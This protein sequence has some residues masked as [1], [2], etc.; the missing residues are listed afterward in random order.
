MQELYVEHFFKI[1]LFWWF[2]WLISYYGLQFPQFVL[3]KLLLLIPGLDLSQPSPIW[4]EFLANIVTTKHQ[5]AA[6]V[7][8]MKRKIVELKENRTGSYIPKWDY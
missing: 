4:W 1:Y 8:L 3:S 5:K 2:L 7:L 6:N